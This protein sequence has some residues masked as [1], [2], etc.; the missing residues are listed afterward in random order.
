MNASFSLA[1]HCDTQMKKNEKKT[2][3]TDH[4]LWLLKLVPI[5][6]WVFENDDSDWATF[7]YWEAKSQYF[8]IVATYRH[9]R[10]LRFSKEVQHISVPQAAEKLWIKKERSTPPGFEPGPAGDK[11]FPS[12]KCCWAESSFSKSQVVIG[13]SFRNGSRKREPGHPGVQTGVVGTVAP[14]W[15]PYQSP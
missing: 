15:I 2:P 5:S 12:V 7:C 8:S 11:G 10:P 9:Y 14:F 4:L 3:S 1:D 6:T 13:T